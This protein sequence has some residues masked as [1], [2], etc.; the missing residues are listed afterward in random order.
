MD[1]RTILAVVLSLAIY[2]G[3]VVYRGATAP[4]PEDAELT[5]SPAPAPDAGPAPVPVP[6]PE[7]PVEIPTP[8]ARELDFAACG[9]RGQVSSAGGGLS[10]LTLDHHQGPYHVTPLYTWVADQVLGRGGPWKPY[11]GDPPAA[12]LVSEDGEAFVAG[13]GQGGPPVP[14]EV[15]EEAPGR[16]VLSGRAANGVLVDR[17]LEEAREGESCTLRST[18]T[19]RN[20]TQQ[21]IDGGT[22]VSMHD[23]VPESHSRYGSQ[24]QPV[25]VV[26]DALVYGGPTGAGCVRA[27]TNLGPDMPRIPLEGPVSW[28]GLSDRYFGLHAVPR[29]GGGHGKAT[30]TR[31]IRG[32]ISLDGTVFTDDRP[33]GPGESR[34]MSFVLYGGPNQIEQLSAVDPNLTKAVDLGWFAFFAWPLL[35]LLRWFHSLL[36]NWGLAIILLTVCVKVLFFRMTQQSFRAMRRMQAIQPLLNEVRQKYA[37]DPQEMNRRTMAVMAEHKVNPLSGCL[38]QLVQ[39]PVWLALYNAL[40]TSVELYHTRFLYLKDLSEPD[41]YLVLPV[42]ITFLM[43]VQ[44][45]LSTPTNLDPVQQQVMRWMPLVFGLLFFAVPS[46]LAVYV[47]VN[48][49][50][51]IV[52]QWLINRSADPPVAAA[53]ASPAPGGAIG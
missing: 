34:S 16:L 33:L 23:V 46:G 48:V 24:R 49:A 6:V 42:A 29:E 1:R 28:F 35:W 53:A 13:A 14:F 22:F 27:G 50:L 2:Y 51:S 3:W 40:L 52:Q 15:V 9:F 5:A 38:P 17:T 7:T 37:D 19:W 39:I 26:D 36:G 18:V 20:E 10:D 4:P 11:G 32:E 25:V 12:I 44:Q 30:L 41:P 45:Q 47:F 43:W 31:E 8:P 21:A